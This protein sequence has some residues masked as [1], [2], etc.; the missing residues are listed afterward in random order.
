MP[1]VVDPDEVDAMDAV[2]FVVCTTTDNKLLQVD[3]AAAVNMCHVLGE[4]MEGHADSDDVV[5]MPIPYDSS[6]LLRVFTYCEHRYLHAE[7]PPYRGKGFREPIMRRPV[8][9]KLPFLFE[10]EWDKQFVIGPDGLVPD[11][12]V[13]KH[14]LLK[15]VLGAC[16]FLHCEWLKDI[17]VTS[18]ASFV[19]GRSVDSLRQ[20]VFGLPPATEADRKQYRDR[21]SWIDKKYNIDNIVANER[22]KTESKK[23]GKRDSKETR[24]C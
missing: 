12:D 16:N 21:F 23:E 17:C 8:L 4:L 19:F 5:V 15:E 1:R 24:K 14:S 20:D 9:K 18:F 6:V 22:K 7:E 11:A 10:N 3:K 2:R 13:S